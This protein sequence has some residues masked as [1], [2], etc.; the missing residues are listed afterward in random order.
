MY[1]QLDRLHQK[2]QPF[3]VSTIETL[4]TDPHLAQQMLA[5]HLDETTPLAS[6]PPVQIDKTVDW[7]DAR[8]QLAGKSVCDLGC[9]PGLYAERFAKRGAHVTG[10]D[11]SANSIAHAQKSATDAGL[12]IT[13]RVAN[14][15]A[16]DLPANQDLVTLIY[17]DLCPLAPEQRRVLLKRVHDM[18]K[19]D[20]AFIFDVLTLPAFEARN[21]EV[22]FAHKAWNGFWSANDY[23]TFQHT[24][25]YDRER[26]TL[27]QYTIVEPER[28]WQVY[29]WLQYFDADTITAELDNHGFEVVELTAG[30]GDANDQT[31]MTIAARAGSS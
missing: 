13:Y 5:Y 4:W 3:S 26:V 6:R 16:D 23:F 27:D 28:T 12:D 15:L 7:I 21:E 30:W 29:N 24:F 17:C 18:L 8:A 14:Y 11:F 10:V 22:L 20:G 31:V 19:P 2:P 9:G 1:E 25:T